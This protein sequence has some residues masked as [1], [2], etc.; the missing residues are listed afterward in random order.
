MMSSKEE[1][2]S[3]ASVWWSDERCNF[4]KL[5]TADTP[6]LTSSPSFVRHAFKK[7]VLGPSSAFK[8][9]MSSSYPGASD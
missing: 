3:L 8:A 9:S 6:W 5:G 2:I 4:D 7:D 1:R